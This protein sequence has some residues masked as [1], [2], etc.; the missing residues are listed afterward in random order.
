M[1]DGPFIVGRCCESLN[2][3]RVC[4]RGIEMFFFSK[5]SSGNIFFRVS[6]FIYQ[7]GKKQMSRTQKREK[8]A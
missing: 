4:A 7:E 3:K 2:G 5:I 6:L 1:D 8:D